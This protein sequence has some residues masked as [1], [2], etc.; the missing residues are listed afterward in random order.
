MI[1]VTAI[2]LAICKLSAAQDEPNTISNNNTCYGRLSGFAR[3]LTSCSHYFY[4]RNGESFRG[5]CDTVNLFDAEID[6][7]VQPRNQNCFRCPPNGF[8]TFSVPNACHQFIECFNGTL[9]LRICSKG[10]VYDGRRE[11]RNCNRPPAT[12]GCYREDNEPDVTPV[13]PAVNARPVFL[14]DPTSCSK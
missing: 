2:L 4:C 8:H 11:K 9:T 13:C 12:G 3:D 1:G 10:L 7:C 5:V 6:Y 14:P